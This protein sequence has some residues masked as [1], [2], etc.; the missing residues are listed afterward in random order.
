MFYFCKQLRFSLIKILVMSKIQILFFGLFF[1]FLVSCKKSNNYVIPIKN[2]RAEITLNADLQ[3]LKATFYQ[4]D[5]FLYEKI[6]TFLPNSI[7][8]VERDN[9]DNIIKTSTFY[10]NSF[11]LADSCVDSVFIS[12]PYLNIT[13]FKYLYD[14][15]GY[16]TSM[17]IISKNIKNDSVIWSVNYNLLFN[18]SNCNL[19]S[20]IFLG[21]SSSSSF[22]YNQLTNKIDIIGFIGG[23][24]GKIDN[25]LCSSVH[26]SGSYAPHTSSPHNAY[27]YTLN[28]DGFVVEKVDLY[29]PSYDAAFEEPQ[30]EKIVT[31]FKY[32]F[33]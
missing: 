25:N 13:I 26:S 4:S 33:Q 20:V 1:L 19:M 2:N 3:I 12:Y 32:I 16:K 17:E 8:S 18:Y 30:P 7:I 14:V 23:Y 22:E 10:L 24:C 9:N 31:K 11:A 5:T 6:N 21:R 27:Y 28:S 15:N 29:T